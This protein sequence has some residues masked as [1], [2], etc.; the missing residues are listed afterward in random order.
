M[1][2]PFHFPADV[3]SDQER[4]RLF[5]DQTLRF[6]DLIIREPDEAVPGAA[7]YLDWEVRRW[8][9]EMVSDAARSAELTMAALTRT[10]DEDLQR[11][12]LSGASLHA[13]LSLLLY[14]QD[15]LW[16][17]ATANRNR[18]FF[19]LG[20]LFKY[21]NTILKSLLSVL[22]TAEPLK[23]LK[24]FVEHSLDRGG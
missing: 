15:R 23:E 8:L 19:L 13:K 7:D 1:P 6:L 22:P 17:V 16:A 24:E 3:G 9:M 10:T 2:P 18:H 20:T 5:V 14:A 4:L 21:I 11:A 12:G